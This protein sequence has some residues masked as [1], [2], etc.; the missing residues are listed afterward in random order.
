[1]L[2][3]P[4]LTSSFTSAWHGIGSRYLTIQLSLQELDY[5]TPSHTHTHTHTHSH[6]LTHTLAH[7]HSHTHTHSL[8]HSLTQVKG[9]SLLP[10]LLLITQGVPARPPSPPVA[11]PTTTS[12][13]TQCLAVTASHQTKVKVHMCQ[14]VFVS[15]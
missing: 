11:T 9:S 10:P 4:F 8:T 2:T 13:L 5:I 7:S 3:T 12:T 15:G 1:M 6:S 14:N